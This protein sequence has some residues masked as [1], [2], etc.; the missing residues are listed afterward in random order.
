MRS[1]LLERWF[2]LAGGGGFVPA[3]RRADS[4]VTGE[5]DKRRPA[6]SAQSDRARS[7]RICLGIGDGSVHRQ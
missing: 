3:R 4:Q 7:H 6:H 1:R 5:P 2:G